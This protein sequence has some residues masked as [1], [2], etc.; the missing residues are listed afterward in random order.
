MQVYNNK[1]YFIGIR[2]I[3]KYKLAVVTIFTSSCFETF[4]MS[5][6][7]LIGRIFHWDILNTAHQIL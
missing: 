3:S 7:F 5:L 6:F 2:I 1:I 4:Q